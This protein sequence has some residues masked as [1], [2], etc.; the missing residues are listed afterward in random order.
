MP[1]GVEHVQN[2]AKEGAAKDV[3]ESLMP[4]GVEH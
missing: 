3:Q 1:Q 2:Q 4:Q